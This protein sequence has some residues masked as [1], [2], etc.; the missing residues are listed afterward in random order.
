MTYTM[1]RVVWVVV[2]LLFV[3]FP[4]LTLLLGSLPPAR[5]FWTEFSAAL[6]YSGL[7]IM[8]LQFGITARFRYVTEPWGEDIIY[9]FHR[10][11]SL[12]AVALVIVHPLIM[13][14]VH[15]ELL[16]VPELSEAPWGAV[17]AFFSLFS[18]IAM[19]VTALW[20][21]K[22]KIPYE[23]WHLS[24]ITLALIAVA[25]G[26]FHMVGWSFYLA[27]P[28]K[29][30]LWFGLTI[31][32]VG[33]LLYVRI[34]KPLFMLRRPYRVTEVR[35]ERGDTTTLVMQPEGHDGF[36]FRTGQFGWL[37]VLGSPFKITAHPFS[38]SSSAAVTDGSVEMS[39]RNLGDFTREIPK[40]RVGQRVYLDGPYGSFTIGN[41]ANMHVLIAG[42]VGVTPMMSMI[43]T[44]ADRGDKRT[45]I[46]F[47]GSKDWDLITFREELEA[48]EARLDLK[49]IHVLADPPAEWS[50][51]RGFI[52]ADV[53]IQHL[54]APYAA[55]EYFI[56]GPDAMMDAI[57]RA[58]AQLDVP[59]SK[60]HAERYSFV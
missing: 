17:A 23:V 40:T 19:V 4:L 13:A 21:A 46:L 28:W 26:L 35:E 44:L 18:L 15:P 29:R 5:D 50:G 25:G 42:G 12:L 36:H 30:A 60:Y 57:E 49:V 10:Q 33:L 20:R 54:P 11:I 43:R 7:A 27:N 16:E 48:L 55:H 22:L 51:E 41:P 24:H 31:F 8:G 1:R 58:L 14:A 9:H 59:M 3:L 47:Y 39:I 32:W 6:G 2:Y 45:V 52:S 56:C 34:I 53:L 38:F 37:T